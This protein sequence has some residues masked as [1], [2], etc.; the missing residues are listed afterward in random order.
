M[1]KTND[2]LA[3][4]GGAPVVPAGMMRPWPPVGARDRELV[5]AS[6]DGSNHTYGPNCKALEEEF[7]AWSGLKHALFANSG[8]AALHMSLVACGCG[9]GDEVIVPAYTWPSSATCCLHHNVIPVFVDIAWDSMNI[10]ID[11]I[12]A[13]ITPR[14]KAIIA[15]HL[16]GLP[17]DMAR[18]MALARKHDL[19][20]IEDCCQAHGAETNGQRIG[21]FGDCAAYSCNQNKIMCCG[22][23]GFFASNDEARF[24]KG[25]TLWYFGEHGRPAAGTELQAYGMGWMYRSTELVAAFARAQL[26]RLDGY[27]VQIRENALRL[28]EGLQGTPNLILPVETPGQRHNWYNYTVRFDMDA[29]GHAHD[30]ARFRDA[31]VKA[32]R[33]EGVATGV[34]QGWPVPEMTAI[35]AKNAY[36]KGCPWACHG[37]AVSYAL[38][39][40]P[41]AL[42]HCAWHTGMTMPL[43][44]PNGP[45]LAEKVGEAFRKVLAQA[46]DIK[47][48]DIL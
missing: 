35:A 16:H 24:A 38:D 36:G 9:A 33:A 29:L 39:Q 5:L 23:G 14:T 21:T 47:L 25:K 26:E 30:A 28:H 40:F 3:I 15:V 37:S 2:R 32:L 6:L 44:P 1:M 45:D 7:A 20:V 17:V 19:R 42:K 27:L 48:D 41:V 8:T 4:H 46:G 12:E 34:W 13:A 18:L 43:R 22:E 31:L 10:D 11:K